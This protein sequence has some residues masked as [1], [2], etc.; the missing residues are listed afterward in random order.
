MTPLSERLAELSGKATDGPWQ[1]RDDQTSEGWV[2]IIGNVD[3]EYVEGQACFTYDVVTVCEDEFG[4]RL[5]NVSA[6]AAL[7][8]EL[9]NAYRA[10]RLIVKD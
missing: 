8:V 6:N 3:G 1:Q 7:I 9:V 10:G 4:E 2:T 5:P